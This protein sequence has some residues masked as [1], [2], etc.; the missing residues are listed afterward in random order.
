MIELSHPEK[1]ISL[2]S[3]PNMKK[4]FLIV[5]L[6]ASLACAVAQTPD[7]RNLQNANLI[8]KEGYV[9]QPYIVINKNG[10]WVCTLTTGPGGES[11]PGQHVVATI[12]SDKG[13]TWSPLIDIEPSNGPEASW[14]MPFITPSGRIYAFYDYNGDLIKDVDGKPS[15]QKLHTALL[16]WYV[17]KYSDDGGKTWS[18]KRF[19]LPMSAA[20]L[21]RNNAW[22]GKVLQFWGI[23]KPEV[24]GTD[25]V[26][27][28]TRFSSKPSP[29]MEEG[30]LYRSD[31]LLTETDP[32]KIRWKLLPETERGIR[33]DAFEPAQ[34]EH[35]IAPLANGDLCCIY[36]TDTGYLASS[37]SR[38]G[39]RTWSTPE[40]PTYASGGKL[41]NPVACPPIW[42]LP[43]GRFLLW[44][45][46]NSFRERGTKAPVGGRNV[47]WLSAGKE[48]DGIIQWSQP[49]IVAY[50]SLDNRN[51]G[52]SYPDLI[53]DGGEYYISCSVKEYAPVFKVDKPL[54]E[55]L[56]QQDESRQVAGKG[57]LS[58]ADAAALEKG[59]L[60][61]PRLPDLAKGGGFSL[62]LQ[63]KLDDLSPG[64]VLLDSR[65]AEGAGIAVTT[66]DAGTLQLAI[67]DGTTSSQWDTDPGVVK[68]GEPS[69]VTFIVDGGPKIISVVVNGRL[70]DGGEARPFGWGRFLA[71]QDKAGGRDRK[72]VGPD[73]GDVSGSETLKIAPAMKGKVEALRIYD[74]YLRTSEA[75]GNHRASL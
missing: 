21:D 54:V 61:M 31:N 22:S 49:E 20:L 19:R 74:R 56:L 66:T 60:A 50:H 8:P 15:S 43:D 51:R 48:K 17:F 45:H 36:R 64:Q 69:H 35:N 2:P 28:F 57:L 7:P 25:V 44:Y 6:T 40:S 29:R 18:D 12:S 9:D 52:P 3:H 63:V 23:D 32:E 10:D 53:L 68:A 11:Q 59:S 73:I 34:Q 42:R 1:Q 13:R 75:V 27:G 41:K 71:K 72:T 26:F 47:A 33:G 37:Y 30:W 67:S 14:V 5:G 46:N 62:D 38:D 55:G 58:K 65:N 39:G 24:V 16:G 70:C 4:V